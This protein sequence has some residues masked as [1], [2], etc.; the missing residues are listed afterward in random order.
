MS[1]VGEVAFWIVLLSAPELPQMAHNC[2]EDS[3]PFDSFLPITV[4]VL[5]RSVRIDG[6]DIL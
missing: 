5:A 2:G 3:S 4:G 6:G 1:K